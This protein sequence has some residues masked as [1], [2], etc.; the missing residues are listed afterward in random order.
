MLQTNYNISTDFSGR[1]YYGLTIDCNYEQGFVDISIAK[2]YQKSAGE[3]TYTPK[4][5]N[6]SHT[7]V[8][9]PI[10][11]LKYNMPNH[12]TAQPQLTKTGNAEY[13]Q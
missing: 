4:N 13:N 1:N 11:D 7:N 6:F 5:R 12:Q 8:L 3:F 9:D 10:T 2:L